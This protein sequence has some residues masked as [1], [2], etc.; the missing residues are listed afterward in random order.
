MDSHN[1]L[2][3]RAAIVSDIV[4]KLQGVVVSE[5]PAVDDATEPEL[6]GDTLSADS[7]ART[8]SDSD[9]SSGQTEED[10][11]WINDTPKWD[12]PTDLTLHSTHSSSEWRRACAILNAVVSKAT[13]TSVPVTG[14][15]F[16]PSLFASLVI[17][18]KKKDLRKL[19]HAIQQPVQPPYLGEVSFDCSAIHTREDVDKLGNCRESLV[20][21]LKLLYGQEQID[22]NSVQ[23]LKHTTPVHPIRDA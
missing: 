9:S 7:E 4:Q 23:S 20:E 5:A 11:D 22:T 12:P 17:K 6:T 13:M 15:T 8:P 3:E 19:K 1:I 18:P 21:I 10:R 16:D 2:E 14:D